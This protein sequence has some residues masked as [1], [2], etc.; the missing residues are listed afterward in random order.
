MFLLVGTKLIT[1]VSIL[2]QY[3]FLTLTILISLIVYKATIKY[4]V[5]W[6][7]VLYILIF[8]PLVDLKSN[9]YAY[10]SRG[11]HIIRT[12]KFNI[13]GKL[14]YL[15]IST[16]I[17]NEYM[18]ST[19]KASI[20]SDKSLNIWPES[21]V[22]TKTSHPD[23]GLEG[24][25]LSGGTFELNHEIYNGVALLD[26]DDLKASIVYR[27]RS[28]IPFF[29][30]SYNRGS[31]ETVLSYYGSRLWIAICW[32]AIVDSIY[33]S[34]KVKESN[35]L[36]I[37]ANTS[38]S[39]TGIA[40]NWYKQIVRLRAVEFGKTILVASQENS[41]LVDRSG[42]L[43]KPCKIKQSYSEY[44]FSKANLASKTNS[45]YLEKYRNIDFLFLSTCFICLI[46]AAHLEYKGRRRHAL[47]NLS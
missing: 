28:T 7:I 42:R 25:I 13:S 39:G 47:K 10:L 9:S 15:A 29:E 33:K 4:G 22:F 36:L 1:L 43:I 23:N 6:S 38:F 5:I 34:V 41:F 46:F 24:N 30:D 20:I 18:R 14:H 26:K 17:I 21:S 27:K 45:F 44:C 37:F 16:P 31:S 32:E 12:Y 2:G 8:L 35:I 40:S 11:N 3:W 19:Q